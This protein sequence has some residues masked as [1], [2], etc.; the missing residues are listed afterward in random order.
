MS[1]EIRR[2]TIGGTIQRMTMFRDAV[3]VLLDDGGAFN[4][5]GDDFCDG[6][7]VRVTVTKVA[8]TLPT[9]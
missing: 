4:L 8:P 1:D 5:K 6:D 9:K 7:T 3:V 2:V